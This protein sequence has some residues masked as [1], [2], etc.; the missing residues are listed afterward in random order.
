MRPTIT[1]N[2]S[3]KRMKCCLHNDKLPQLT[4]V[5][6]DPLDYEGLVALLVLLVLRQYHLYLY[7]KLHNDVREKRFQNNSKFGLVK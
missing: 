3:L 2:F 7:K 1:A 4:G 6:T 5:F